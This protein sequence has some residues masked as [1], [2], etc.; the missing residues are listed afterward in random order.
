MKRAT[1]AA[2]R[3]N[4][5]EWHNSK[6]F[7]P[8]PYSSSSS[9]RGKKRINCQLNCNFQNYGNMRTRLL[10]GLIAKCHS[11]KLLHFLPSA[12]RLVREYFPLQPLDIGEVFL[13][14]SRLSRI[15]EKNP[16]KMSL[17]APIPRLD[18]IR[19]RGDEINIQ[20]L[21]VFSSGYGPGL[22]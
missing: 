1:R 17:S 3:L 18:I 4:K 21:S 9:Y 11:M 10:L 12:L 2:W 16:Y 13:A 7:Y 14:I 8:F 19:H 15:I 5:L 22:I 6:P 20:L